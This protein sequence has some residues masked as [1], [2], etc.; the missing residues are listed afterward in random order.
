MT[1]VHNAV[2]G[3]PSLGRFSVPALRLEAEPGPT[4]D[5]FGGLRRG[6]RAGLAP[7]LVLARSGRRG[8][9]VCAAEAPLPRCPPG[10]VRLA[11]TSP[12]RS[13]AARRVARPVSEPRGCGRDECCSED[14][15]PVVLVRA[16]PARATSGAARSRRGHA[17]RRC[18]RRCESAGYVGWWIEELG[19]DQAL[20]LSHAIWPISRSRRSPR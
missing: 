18:V 4:R 3:L 12:G 15:R 16:V 6:S 20:E 8:R 9:R 17:G 1:F 7:C 13:K 11:K 5:A 2:A 10:A 14:R 19:R